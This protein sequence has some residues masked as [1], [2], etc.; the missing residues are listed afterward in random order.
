MDLQLLVVKAV[1]RLQQVG[2]RATLREGSRLLRRQRTTDDGFDLKYGTDTAGLVKLWNFKVNSPNARFG[3]GY[4]TIDEQAII[5]AIKAIPED[6][7]ALTFI[8][9]GCGKGKALLVAANLGFK[10]VIGVEFVH[11]LAEIA[12]TNLEKMGIANAVVVQT[13]AAK[14]RFPNSDMVVYFFNPFQQEV[15]KQVIANLRESLTKKLYVI[16]ATPMY[17]VLFDATGFLTRLGCPPGRPDI[18]IWSATTVS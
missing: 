2:L 18:Q 3:V 10:R 8:D 9:I 17:A 11:E 15:M 6:L 7:H 1:R 12:K 16:Y 13:D 4:Q 5:D 14:Y